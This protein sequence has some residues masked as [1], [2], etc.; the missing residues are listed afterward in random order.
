MFDYETKALL[1]GNA[2][3]ELQMSVREKPVQHAN[4]LLA[5]K[6]SSKEDMAFTSVLMSAR[7]IEDCAPRANPPRDCFASTTSH[8][9]WTALRT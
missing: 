9:P 5:W 7:S 1:D 8:R 2:A 6:T 4:L 3:F